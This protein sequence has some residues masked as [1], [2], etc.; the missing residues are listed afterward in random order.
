MLGG[1]AVAGISLDHPLAT[2]P[3]SHQTGVGV[4]IPV[5]PTHRTVSLRPQAA[6]RTGLRPVTA[7]PVVRELHPLQTVLHHEVAVVDVG[8]AVSAADHVG[9]L[10]TVVL[11]IGQTGVILTD[12]PANLQQ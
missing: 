3:L 6:G 1:L 9:V 8:P 7:G 4:N 12:I 5:T 10:V 11:A 2:G